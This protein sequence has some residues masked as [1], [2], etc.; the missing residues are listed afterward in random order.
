MNN[1]PASIQP[2]RRW[3][4]RILIGLFTLLVTTVIGRWVWWERTRAQGEEEL[5]A[6]IA[7]TEAVDPRWRWEQIEEDRPKV[8]DEENSIL[9]LK[10][11]D[12]SMSAMDAD[13]PGRRWDPVDL[14]LPN[15]EKLLPDLID[16]HFLDD[17]RLKFLR[18]ELKGH[19]ASIELA[20]V[21][22][23]FPK[24]RA[25][26]HV[27]SNPFNTLL[28]HDVFCRNAGLVLVLDIERLL[29]E[30]RGPAV[31]MR[32]TAMLNAG[33]GLKGEG[34]LVSQL[35]RITLRIL[36]ARRLERVLAIGESLDAD[37]RQM[38]MR[39]ASEEA[40]ELLIPAL[41]GERALFTIFFENLASGRMTLNEIAGGRHGSEAWDGWLGWT[42][43]KA[44]L[45]ADQA[46]QLRTMKELIAIAQLPTHEQ[47]EQIELFH[48]RF[49]RE[50]HEARENKERIMSALLLPATDKLFEAAIRD[51]A[52]LRC[53]I[54]ALAA[55]RYRLENEK[56]EW[57]KKLDD[58]SPKYL[59]SVPLDPFDGQPLKYKFRDD[60]VTIYSVG[61]DGVD[62]GGTNLTASGREP[63]ADLGFR[64]WNPDQRGLPPL[65]KDDEAK[66]P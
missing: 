5:A 26:L 3:W 46:Y 66:R 32:I 47:L 38:Q 21:A 37:L 27:K 64:L 17:D 18:K 54:A 22:K 44:R 4:W 7:E 49:R 41:R 9:V 51:K 42:L 28:P 50:S 59:D 35:V 62:N 56:K 52:L 43:Y 30:G 8:P 63:G 33:A 14:K 2:R 61:A 15:G 65:T 60:G 1:G 34:L 57:P 58:L 31:W 19:E 55:E 6:A 29:H 25:A 39:L 11:F 10:R 16:N 20:A 12:E 45:P 53:T 36:A 48:A 23:D 24:G 40:E 13:Q